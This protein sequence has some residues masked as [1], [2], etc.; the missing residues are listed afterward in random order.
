M[1]K[2]IVH[3]SINKGGSMNR[4]A[5]LLILSLGSLPTTAALAD[6]GSIAQT[7]EGV[8]SDVKGSI[9]DVGTH[10]QNVFKELGI[11]QS[12]VNSENFGAKQTFQGKKGNMD[13]VVQLTRSSN[14]Q[15]HA[16]VTAKQ[17]TLS[18]NKDF[19]QQILSKI[20]EAS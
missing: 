13:V 18:W 16:I 17:G 12:G 9:A 14:D 2:L 3:L 4:A 19:A 8:E 5:I 1:H 15:T 7:V 6:L 10:T 11:Q 20:I